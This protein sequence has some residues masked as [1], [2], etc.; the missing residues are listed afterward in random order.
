MTSL[1]FRPKPGAVPPAPP[2]SPGVVGQNNADA[3]RLIE[4]QWPARFSAPF[5][6]AE[7]VVKLDDERQL[8]LTNWDGKPST[9]ERKTLVLLPREDRYEKEYT[10]FQGNL[11]LAGRGPKSVAAQQLFA[12]LPNR[13]GKGPFK[14]TL[15]RPPQTIYHDYRLGYLQEFE[16]K[17]S[18][19]WS[20]RP[21]R[22]SRLHKLK[23]GHVVVA[24]PH[25]NLILCSPEC[26]HPRGPINPLRFV[27]RACET[28]T[29]QN[30]CRRQLISYIS[31]HKR[32]KRSYLDKGLD[33]V[34]KTNYY[35]WLETHLPGIRRIEESVHRFEQKR[36]FEG[37]P[38]EVCLWYRDPKTR[39]SLG[40]TLSEMTL[41]DNERDFKAWWASNGMQQRVQSEV[42]DSGT[43]DADEDVEGVVDR[44]MRPVDQYLS[45]Q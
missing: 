13:V 3:L 35:T 22:D 26:S 19:G 16:S 4:A 27:C 43:A 39:L 38:C 14:E 20:A 12:W 24:P 45:G 17:P 40:E 6:N 9:L 31:L 32:M 34:P 8:C 5:N 10:L 15:A 41:R 2:S 21:C 30:E 11:S 25:P 29:C 18:D 7:L 36:R 37:R 33:L 42:R 28:K 23:C 44:L 1:P